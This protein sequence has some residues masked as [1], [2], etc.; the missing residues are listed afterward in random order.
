MLVRLRLGIFDISLVETRL[1]GLRMRQLEP[2]IGRLGDNNSQK[3]R[4]ARIRST[5][6]CDGRRFGRNIHMRSIRV[7]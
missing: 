2:E 7:G 5:R 4:F 6:I 1:G 3:L